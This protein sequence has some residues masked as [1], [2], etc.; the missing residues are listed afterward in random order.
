MHLRLDEKP[1]EENNRIGGLSRLI[2]GYGGKCNQ[3]DRVGLT[4]IYG[5]KE[6]GGMRLFDAID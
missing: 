5:G 6:A 1:D 3:D 4:A 2:H